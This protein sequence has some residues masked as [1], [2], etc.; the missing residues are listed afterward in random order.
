MSDPDTAHFRDIGSLAAWS[1]SSSKPGYGVEHL[2]DPNT[3]TLWQ[4]EGPQPHLINIQFS[5]K[6][7]I[8][9]ISLYADVGLDD[10]YT[11]QKISLRAGTYHGDLH[12][13]RYV[14]MVSPNGWQHF[15]LAGRAAEGGNDEEW[16]VSLCLVVGCGCEP[17]RAHLIQIAIISNHLNGKDTHVRGVKVFAPRQSQMTDG[18]MPFTTIAFRQHETIR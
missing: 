16:V 6:Q 2:S 1:V 4:S 17:I 7:S 12:E 11:P 13:V 9:Q 5:R 14:E 15:K 18:L 3:N 8:T 10:S